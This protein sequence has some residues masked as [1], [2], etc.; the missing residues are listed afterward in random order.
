MPSVATLSLPSILIPF[1]SVIS[2]S[3][4]HLPCL[5]RDC[6][7]RGV[8]RDCG[9]FVLFTQPWL[10]CIEK[11]ECVFHAGRVQQPCMYAP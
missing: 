4:G 9:A 8:S 5:Y 11:E 3:L 6:N 10:Y 7:N 1:L 2:M